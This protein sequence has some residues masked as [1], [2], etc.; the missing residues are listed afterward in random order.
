[1]LETE[2]KQGLVNNAQET[3]AAWAISGLWTPAIA[4]AHASEIGF[5]HKSNETSPYEASGG[6]A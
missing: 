5:S 6:A 4:S 3:F 1:M 2:P